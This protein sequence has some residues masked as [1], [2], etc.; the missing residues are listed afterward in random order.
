VIAGAVCA[1]DNAGK[2]KNAMACEME[3]KRYM[4][5]KRG[6]IKDRLPTFRVSL[7]FKRNSPGGEPLLQIS[8]NQSVMSHP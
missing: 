4:E 7:F 8:S 3:N 2:T 1:C 6:R 5:E